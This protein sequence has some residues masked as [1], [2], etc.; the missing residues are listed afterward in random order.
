MF[1]RTETS[2]QSNV[3]WLRLAI[4]TT[5]AVGLLIAIASSWDRIAKLAG[6]PSSTPL[7]TT[8]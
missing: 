6:T 1:A 8:S 2:V 7:S 4:D 5:G 3:E